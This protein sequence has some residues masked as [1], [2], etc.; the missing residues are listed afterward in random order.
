MS[1]KIQDRFFLALLIAC[2][3]AACSAHRQPAVEAGT[4]DL[5]IRLVWEGSTDLDLFVEDPA[6][7]C[8]F[9]ASRDSK[10][11]AILDVDCNGTSDNMCE[12]PIE[13]VY[14]PAST[15]PVGTY[16]YW[17]E[18]H[19]IVPSDAPIPFEIQLLRGDHIVWR[20]QGTAQKQGEI[21]GPFAYPFSGKPSEPSPT[22]KPPKDCTVQL[23]VP[24]EE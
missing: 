17:V 14:W 2:L 19:S 24:A 15:A 20:Q 13:N 18:T 7:S 23:Y 10:T 3:A 6:G 22:G 8:V 1:I 11:G 5:A 4:G 21:F 9:F 16:T 12:R